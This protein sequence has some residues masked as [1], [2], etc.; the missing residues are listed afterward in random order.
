MASSRQELNENY[1]L[2]EQ[3]ANQFITATLM[4]LAQLKLARKVHSKAVREFS[5]AVNSILKAYQNQTLNYEQSSQLLKNLKLGFI[6]GIRAVK[7]SERHR[8]I[9]HSQRPQQDGSYRRNMTVNNQSFNVRLKARCA[10]AEC[11]MMGANLDLQDDAFQEYVAAAAKDRKSDVMTV[12][13]M[14]LIAAPYLKPLELLSHTD[15]VY[16]IYSDETLNPAWAYAAGKG[17][18]YR[19]NLLGIS[20]AISSRVENA[21]AFTTGSILNE[22]N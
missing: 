11:L 12:V 5:Q 2:L 1:W 20:K 8:K 3:E 18:A 22:A 7:T 16:T 10:T 21:T 15:N 19:L 17:A 14:T 6:G 4:Q 13:N 9:R